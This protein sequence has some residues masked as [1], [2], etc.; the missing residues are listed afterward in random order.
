MSTYGT[1]G[2]ERALQILKVSRISVKEYPMFT[3][4]L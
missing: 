2:V 4:L 3:L 1:E